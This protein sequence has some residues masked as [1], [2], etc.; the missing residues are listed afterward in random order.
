[1]FACFCEQFF[2][3]FKS[4]FD[5]Y[6]GQISVFQVI[7]NSSNKVNNGKGFV[8]KILKPFFQEV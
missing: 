7:F 2:F 3:K 6:R 8:N 4:V 5:A 1:M